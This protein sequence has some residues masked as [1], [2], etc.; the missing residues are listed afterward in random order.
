MTDI[1]PDRRPGPV[2]LA[3]LAVVLL[4]VSWG[5][6][7]FSAWPWAVTPPGAA[8]LRVSL[9]SVTGLTASAAPPREVAN[10]PVHMRPPAGAPP[11]TGRRSDAVLTV[12]IDG[13]TVLVR[14]YR[15]TGLR[16]DGPVYAY[17]EIPLPPGRHVV[18]ATLADA[19]T[20]AGARTW[21]AV[22]AVTVGPG[23]APLLGFRD[24]TWRW[25]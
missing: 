17:E 25:D 20:G 24:G 12:A 11:T 14:T 2:R 1:V 19:G 15:P 21:S 16:R 23:E 22:S 4:V 9:R 7:T 18:Q 13:V 3:A 8:L 5:L 10:L 6:A